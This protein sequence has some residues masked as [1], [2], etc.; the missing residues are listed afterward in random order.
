MKRIVLALLMP[1]LLTGCFM[2]PGKFTSELELMSG[3]RFAF[4]YVGEIQFIALSKL[5]ELGSSD[6]FTAECEDEDGFT[7]ECSEEETSEQ[8]AEWDAGAQERAAK[9][10]RNAEQMKLMMGGLDPSDP[11]AAE[12]FASKLRRQRGWNRVDYKGDG[13]FDV[14]FSINGMLTHDFAFPSIEK[15]PAGASFLNVSLRN[16][17]QVRIDAPGFASQGAGNPMAGMMGGM[18]GLA[19]LGAQYDAAKSGEEEPPALVLPQG[20]F[21]IVTDGR[22]LANNTDEGAAGPASRQVLSWAIEPSTEAAPTAL[23]AF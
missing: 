22:V 2:T 16:D 9:K 11:Q 8:R 6:E 5:S 23:I 21:R 15:M 12:E 20:T 18:M 7:R 13:L 1:L 3:D 4:T 19:Q 17:G 14:S 10:A